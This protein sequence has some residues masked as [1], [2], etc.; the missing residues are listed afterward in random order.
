MDA[1]TRITVHA[2]NTAFASIDGVLYT[3]D[4]TTLVKYPN[5]KSGSELTLPKETVRIA[6]GALSTLYYNTGALLLE[7][8][9]LTADTVEA[10]VKNYGYGYENAKYFEENP[11]N[12]IIEKLSG[13]KAIYNKDGSVLQAN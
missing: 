8:V 13:A 1:L 3:K 5:A 11:W 2:D 7:K 12:T 6:Y 4:L 10:G 9:Y